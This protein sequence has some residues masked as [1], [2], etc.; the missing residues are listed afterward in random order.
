MLERERAKSAQLEAAHMDTLMRLTRAAAYK[1]AET[2]AHLDRLAEY[3]RLLAL[4]LGLPDDVAMRV[5][6]A[7]PLHDVG[8]IGIPDA[9]LT[10]A[11]PLD[12]A[13]WEIMRRHPAIGA[14]L[15]KGSSSPL[16]ESARMIALTHHEHWD[17][18]GYPKGLLGEETPLEGRIV[19]FV[20]RYDAL[21][22]PRRYKEP[23]DHVTV[24]QMMLEGC[25]R[26]RPEHFDPRILEAFRASH[27]EFGAIYDRQSD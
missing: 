8:K 11:G 26:T 5:G 22:S 25:D 18:S 24:C 3:S 12:D 4:R 19:M 14:S 6:A 1:D 9:I 2:G 16:I 21:R 27:A 10:K 7:A 20:D 15:L 23:Y 13:E 17:G